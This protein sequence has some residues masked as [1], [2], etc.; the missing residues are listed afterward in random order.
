MI[1]IRLRSYSRGALVGLLALAA[2][3]PAPARAQEAGGDAHK[4]ECASAYAETQR[5]RQGGKQLAALE[6][7]VFCAQPTCPDLLVGDCTRWV[8]ELE[9]SLPS[10]VIEARDAAGNPL[11]NVAVSI[12]GEALAERLDGRA[13][14]VDPGEHHFRFERDGQRVERRLVVVEGSKNQR[15][16]VEFPAAA[17]DSSRQPAPAINGGGLTPT[18]YVTAAL[19]AAGG[20]GFAY[21]GLRGNDR[22][23]EL[24]GQC[25]P[26][27]NDDDLSPVRRD[28]LLADISL[29]VSLVSLGAMTWLLLSDGGEQAPAELE[30]SPGA[31]ALRYRARF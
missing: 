18:V 15:L 1:P 9:A 20:V 16:L 27:C 13:L 4:A 31:A 7:A 25:A 10:V 11:A 6:R 8:S 30:L 29:G 26:R 2:W 3:W 24:Q 19:A 5:L 23:D 21:F 12:D 14:R 17:S 28:W 22:Y